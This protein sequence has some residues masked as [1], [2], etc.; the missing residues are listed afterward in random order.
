MLTWGQ[1]LMSKY[2]KFCPGHNGDMLATL[3]RTKLS[4]NLARLVP[5]LKEELEYITAT[6]FPECKGMSTT[7]W[8]YIHGCWTLLYFFANIEP[9]D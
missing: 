9:T 8:I 7:P 6:E 4:Q 2:T 5:Q 1:A 3:V